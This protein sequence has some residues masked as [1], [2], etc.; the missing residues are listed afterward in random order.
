MK[1]NLLKK[2]VLKKTLLT[3]LLIGAFFGKINAAYFWQVSSIL[4]FTGGATY[5]VGAPANPLVL[6]IQQCAGGIGQPHNSTIYNQTLYVNTLNSTVG[7]TVVSSNAISTPWIFAPSYSY[8]PSTATAGT[9]YYYYMLTSPSMTTCG[10]TGTLTSQIATVTVAGPAAALN[11]DG[12]NDYVD[13]G[14]GITSSLNNSD[15]LTVE[16]WVNPTSITGVHSIV[17]NHQGPTQFELRT[18]GNTFNFFIGFGAFGV[19]STAT[20][21]LNTWQHI[22]GVFDQNKISIYVNGVFSGSTAVTSFS[23]PVSTVTAKIGLDGFSSYYLGSI[24]EVR[25]WKEARTQC[26]INTY[27]NCE[28]P[29]TGTNLL[30]N[31]HFNQGMDASPN[32]TVTTLTDASG[33]AYTG[34]LTNFALTG[35]TSNWRAPGGVVSGFTTA[36]APPTVGSTVTNSVICSGN[37]TTLNGTGATTYMWTGGVTDG[38]AF[39]PTTTASYTVTGT[40]ASTGCTNTA[41]NSVTV[42]T[43]P[44]ITVNSGAICSGNSFTMIPSGA[45]T[46]TF[47]GGSAVVSPTANAS[48]SVTG[49]STQG[50]VSSNTAVSSVTVNSLPVVTAVSTTSLLCVGNTASLTAGGANTYTW[51]TTATTTVIAISPTVTTSYSVTG[52]GANGC[53]N[54]AIITQNVSNCTGINYVSKN[55]IQ[56][57][58][59]PNPNNGVFNLE[60]NA[61]AQISIINSLGQ[62]IWNEKMVSGIHVLDLKDNAKGIYFIKVSQAYN[63][64]TIKLIKQ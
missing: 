32:P 26:Q 58:V 44:I 60:L 29:T 48:Y 27:M 2:S 18:N 51:S 1:K 30:A 41:V 6:N 34:A 12:V 56:F 4:S 21:T 11:F 3:V 59:Y 8:T 28:I 52:T 36:L 5:A 46:Y 42:N 49:T 47:S 37:S 38:V 54:M 53:K 61:D 24:D 62:E 50:C 39:S 7:G 33:N 19:T 20:A 55:D 43:T 17:G 16:A 31:Y 45:N 14:T 25:I 23:L 22:A 35:A 15:K 10:F 13:L 63:Q 64:Q 57:N 9:L 40:V